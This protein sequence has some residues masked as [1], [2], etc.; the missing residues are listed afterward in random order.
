MELSH[1]ADKFSHGLGGAF[2]LATI[3]FSIVFM[4]LM[5]LTFIIYATRYLADMTSRRTTPPAPTQAKPV[6]TSA[7]ATAAPAG[8]DKS[9]IAAVIAAAVAAS[10]GGRTLS[11]R[12]LTV[13]GRGKA[14]PW[15]TA[16]RMDL[17]EGFD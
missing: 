4:V 10:G 6:Q 14:S 12:P 5:A 13:T 17:I 2:A 11:I 15:K 16:G 8:T 3:A 1:I 9:I 7:A